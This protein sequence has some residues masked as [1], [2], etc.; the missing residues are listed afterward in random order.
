MSIA[1]T[2]VAH[3]GNMSNSSRP[4]T[5]ERVSE[6]TKKVRC[7]DTSRSTMYSL[8]TNVVVFY[9]MIIGIWSARTAVVDKLAINYVSIVDV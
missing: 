6:K 7:H 4:S 5:E 9:E 3:D 1:D 8:C 2:E